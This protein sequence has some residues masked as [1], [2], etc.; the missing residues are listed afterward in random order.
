MVGGKFSKESRLLTSIEYNRVFSKGKK[1]SDRYFIVFADR[2]CFLKP[3]LGLAISRKC[4]KK[5]VDRNRLKRV[6]RDFF[7]STQH[8]IENM[9]LV[10]VGRPMSTEVGNKTLRSSLQAHFTRL[11]GLYAKSDR[12]I[13]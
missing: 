1:S 3:R 4:S 5:A 10:I 11:N 13:A 7:R 12:I 2:N 6:A 9:D 8:E